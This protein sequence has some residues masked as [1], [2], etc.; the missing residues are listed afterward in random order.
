MNTH[1]LIASF[2]PKNGDEDAISFCYFECNSNEPGKVEDYL[3]D[4]L[5][6]AEICEII[7]VP[8]KQ[9]NQLKSEAQLLQKQ[10]NQK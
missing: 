3:L 10:I 6:Y 1:Y 8:K 4:A 9:F 5:G 2:I 7:E